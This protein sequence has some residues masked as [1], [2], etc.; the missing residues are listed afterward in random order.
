MKLWAGLIMGLILGIGLAFMASL[1]WWQAHPKVIEV[2]APYPVIEY[3]AITET[4]YIDRWHEP[5]VITIT[6]NNTIIKEVEVEK[7]V[8]EKRTDWRF[9]ETL[10]EFTTWLEGKLIYLMPPADCDDYA[11]NLQLEAY[12]DGYIISAQLVDKDGYLFGKKVI[13]GTGAHDMIRVNIGNEIYVVEPQSDT[14]RI[15]WI[16]ERD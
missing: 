2:P 13:D 4:E 12:K 16:G 1:V 14:F 10:P 6:E 8:Y 9:F 15:I 3:Q 11:Q 7:V 5:E